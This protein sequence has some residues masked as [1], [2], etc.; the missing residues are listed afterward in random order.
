MTS[1][2]KRCIATALPAGPNGPRQERHTPDR[3]AVSHKLLRL[4][5]DIRRD[6]QRYGRPSRSISTTAS[7]P[8]SMIFRKYCCSRLPYFNQHLNVRSSKILTVN[9][10]WCFT[11]MFI[12]SNYCSVPAPLVLMYQR[13]RGRRQQRERFCKRGDENSVSTI[14]GT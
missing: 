5:K 6:C 12:I 14:T 2:A 8:R 1:K 4:R 10:L 3:L 7:Y 11:S 9:K 13:Y